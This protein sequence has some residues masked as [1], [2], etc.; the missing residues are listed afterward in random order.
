MALTHESRGELSGA[1]GFAIDR[2]MRRR[3]V[4]SLYFLASALVMAAVLH[5][6]VA[7]GHHF[8]AGWLAMSV[9]GWL[10]MLGASKAS[11]K[12]SEK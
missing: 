12:S 5:Q 3:L 11:Y 8:I 9:L 6:L 7:L 1:P 10:F 4:N 2:A